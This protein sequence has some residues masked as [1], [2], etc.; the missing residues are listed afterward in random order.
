MPNIAEQPQNGTYTYEDYLSWDDGLR[1]ELIDGWAYAMAAAT[2]EHQEIC[3]ELAV[4]LR[5][6]LKDGPCK[7]YPDIDVRLMPKEIKKGNLTLLQKDRVFRPDLSVV[8]DPEQISEKGCAGAPTLIVEV[9]SPSN[10]SFDLNEKLNCYLQAGVPEYWAVSPMT[11]TVQRYVL[12]DDSYIL[13]VF[14]QTDPLSS[15]SFPGLEIT[16]S[17]IFPPRTNES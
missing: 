17:D 5:A 16:L 2:P 12:K 11:R 1:Y 7:V 13:Q 14:D 3:L 10:A 15:Q 6:F 4:A 9:L 8:C